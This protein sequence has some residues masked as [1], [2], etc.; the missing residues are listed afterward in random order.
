MTDDDSPVHADHRIQHQFP[1]NVRFC[2]LCGGE[3]R[4]RVVLPDHK[5]FKV[6]NICGFVYFPGP[7]LVAGCFV[8]DAGRVL[9]LRRGIEPQIGKWTFP[10]GYVDLGETP[11]AAALR[12]TREE[13]G[14]Q[15]EL[16]PVLGVYSD[17]AHPVA[18]VIVYIAKPG[19]EEASVTDEA[20]EVHYFAPADIPWREI[21][22]ST[23]DGA[24]RDWLGTL[25]MKRNDWL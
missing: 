11:A 19:I 25:E 4:M 15:V 22:F 20:T 21:A 8:I 2:A 9:L 16:G 13:V 23:T 24:L 3:M 14:M 6:C 17:S 7:K 1:H 18:A 5:R 12:E 10:G